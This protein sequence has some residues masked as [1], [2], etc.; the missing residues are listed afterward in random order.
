[1]NQ[2]EKIVE[3]Q[4]LIFDYRKAIF[5]KEDSSLILSDIHVGKIIHFQKNGIPIPSTGS[6]DNL[7]NLKNLVAEYDPLRVYIL[8]DLFHSYYNK[9]WDEWLTYIETS[10]IKFTLILGNHDPIESRLVLKSNIILSSDLIR[11]PFLFTHYP[12]KSESHFNICGHIHP[13]VRLKGLGRQ[14]L[15]LHCFYVSENQL[16]LPAF[17]KFTGSHI[18]KPKKTDYVICLSSKGVFEL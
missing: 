18:M 8:G 1:M 17:G 4:Q 13:A 16:I 9:E 6:L 5:W 7:M 2:I 3:G 15:K 11:G 10:K 12:V 14:Y